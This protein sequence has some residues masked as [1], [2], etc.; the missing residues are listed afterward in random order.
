M[1]KIYSSEYSVQNSKNILYSSDKK[2]QIIIF[3]TWEF[4]KH[5]EYSGQYNTGAV[6]INNNS[7]SKSS[8][9]QLIQKLQQHIYVYSTVPGI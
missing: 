6:N 9:T 7:A 5:R 2:T 1:L 3:C 8:Y 4:E